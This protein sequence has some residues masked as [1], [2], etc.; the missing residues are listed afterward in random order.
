MMPKMSKM[1]KNE[2]IKRNLFG[3]ARNLTKY[4]NVNH[5][6]V[7]NSMIS[8]VFLE[9]VNFLRSSGIDLKAIQKILSDYKKNSLKNTEVME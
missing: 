3:L 1:E 4:S 6:T 2:M 7:I 5:P 8:I 9:S